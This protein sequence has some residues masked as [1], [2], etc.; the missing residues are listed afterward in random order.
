MGI[1]LT[2]FASLIV[3][4]TLGVR[5]IGAIFFKT[6]RN[7]LAKHPFVYGALIFF[8]LAV[9]FSSWGAVYGRL[10]AKYDISRGHFEIQKYG[11]MRGPLPIYSKIL[12]DRYNVRCP[13]ISGCMVTPAEVQFKNAYNSVSQ[14]AII[15]HFGKDIFT[16]SMRAAEE[17]FRAKYHIKTNS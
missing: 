14:P 3:A 2:Y 11:L 4:I 12:K 13:S 8:V 16:E 9:W 5:F 1:L 6:S 10:S 17:E 15:E 7:D